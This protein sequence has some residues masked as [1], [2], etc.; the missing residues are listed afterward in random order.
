MNTFSNN[1]TVQKILRLPAVK[2]LTGCSRTWIYLK[3]SQGNFPQSIS[4]GTRSVG[5]LESEIFA[6]IEQRINASR[7]SK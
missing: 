2:N 6:W 1:S 4:L 7:Q 3:M 5:W